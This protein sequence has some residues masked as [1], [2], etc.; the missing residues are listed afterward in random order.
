MVIYICVP[1]TRKMISNFFLYVLVYFVWCTQ[2][3]FDSSLRAFFYVLGVL[4]MYTYCYCHN[5]T[6][7]IGAEKSWRMVR[8]NW[9][10]DVK[11]DKVK[12]IVWIYCVCVYWVCFLFCFVF[13]FD[14][15]SCLCV[16]LALRH[17]FLMFTFAPQHI[18]I[19]TITIK[20]FVRFSF[21]FFIL[22]FQRP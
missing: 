3:H 12:Q 16:A 18:H 19:Y 10:I 13:F 17:H 15:T 7:V 11:K 4:K 20:H 1:E 9:R 8:I 21:L 14:S 6:P 5:K 2:I 22:V